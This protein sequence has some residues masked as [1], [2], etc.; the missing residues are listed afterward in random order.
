[1]RTRPG[2]IGFWPAVKPTRQIRPRGRMTDSS[3]ASNR[4]PC[5]MSSTTSTPAGWPSSADARPDLV[6]EPA[7]PVAVPA[8]AEHPV[9]PRRGRRLPL[10]GGADAGDDVRAHRP[11]QLHRGHADA[12]R[13]PVDQ[14]QAVGGHLAEDL[15]EW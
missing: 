12:A 6:L 5:T 10:F 1:M 8:V 4:S 9:G 7:V 3:A 14:H 2:R 13:R 11:G 15:S